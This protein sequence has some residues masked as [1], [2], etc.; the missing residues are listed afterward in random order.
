LKFP[1]TA[2]IRADFTSPDGHSYGHWLVPKAQRQLRDVNGDGQQDLLLVEKRAA[3]ETAGI[4]GVDSTRLQIVLTTADRQRFVGVDRIF[5]DP[6]NILPLP[7][8]HGPASVGTARFV[9]RRGTAVAPE[10]RLVVRAWYP[11]QPTPA[12]PASYFL[13]ELDAALNG[14]NGDAILFDP[15]HAHSVLD[16]AIL[17]PTHQGM[18]RGWPVLLLSTGFGVP[19]TFYSIFAEDAASRGYVVFGV[20]HP[21]GSGTVVY[22]DG[23]SVPFDPTVT[24]DDALNQEWSEDL[25]AVAAA[26]LDTRSSIGRFA[27][28]IDGR[29]IGALG[30]SFG[31]AAA[32]SA[33][34]A[35]RQIRA[36][37]NLDGRIFGEVTS[38]GPNA[39]LFFM[40]S[41]GSMTSTLY[42]LESL[43]EHLQAPAYRSAVTGAAH[44]N[45]TDLGLLFLGLSQDDPTLSASDWGLGTIDPMRIYDIVPE[46]VAAFFGKALTGQASSLLDPE[47]AEFPEVTLQAMSP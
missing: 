8:P 33:S 46:Y 3:F 18:K 10:R 25:Q 31:G 39:P 5:T 35:N 43:L 47:S 2:V 21:G 9:L 6:T 44:M 24:I 36:A 7:E 26:A 23:S 29:R 28:Q 40:G 19:L 20:E 15:V 1:R 37:L 17:P 41:D 34:K 11:A 30:H 16:A 14:G 13:D 4:L 45:F 42:G 32:F 27:P 22:P 38:A 12:Q